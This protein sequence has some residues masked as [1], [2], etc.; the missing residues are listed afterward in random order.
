MALG[1]KPV[2]LLPARERVASA[3]RKAILSRTL[4]DGDT[5][6]LEQTASELGVS[7]TPVREA[8]Q[9]LSHDGLIELKANKGAVVLGITPKMLKDHYNVR[10]LLE[11]E[12]CRLCCLESAD[13]S[14]IR[15]TLAASKLALDSGDDDEYGT[16]NQSFHYEIWI[17]S[18]ND[19]L[20]NMLSELWNGASMG[21]K[22]TA[23]EYAH[24]SY[25]EHVRIFEALES[26]DATAAAD[27]MNAHIMRSLQNILTR[28]E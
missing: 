1:L 13:L 6:T 27:A 23:S 26:R 16:Y 28:Y 24:I 3:L 22:T 5:L 18:G 14:L 20:K 4:K 2:N 11:S 8:F 19:K 12:A 17:A 25:E 10:A 21:I 15:D 7:I 9:I